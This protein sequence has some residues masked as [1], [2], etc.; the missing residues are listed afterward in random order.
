MPHSAPTQVYP[1]LLVLA[2]TL[3][4]SSA[5]CNSVCAAGDP[6]FHLAHGGKADFKGRNDTIYCM[7]SARNLTVNTLFRHDVYNWRSKVVFGSWMKTV[8]ITAEVHAAD[9]NKTF[10]Q[11]SY[12][13]DHASSAQL[14]SRSYSMCIR[15]N[16]WLSVIQ[17][18]VIIS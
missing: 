14:I 11:I 17:N 5:N 9:K 13:P 7:L 18:M 2:A 16:F 15:L 3:P 12:D 6:H 4:T 8:Y 10:V 1:A